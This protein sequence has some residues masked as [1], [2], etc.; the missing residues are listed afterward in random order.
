MDLGD[1]HQVAHHVRLYN[2][3][4]FTYTIKGFAL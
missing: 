4:V 3:K 1:F 2:M